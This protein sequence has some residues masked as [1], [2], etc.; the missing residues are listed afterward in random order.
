MSDNGYRVAH[1]LWTGTALVAPSDGS[2]KDQFGMAAIVIESLD[3]QHNIIAVNVVPGLLE[4]QSSFRSELAGL[5]RQVILINATCTVHNITSGAIES[6][7][8]GKVA[9]EK[10]SQFDEQVD[11]N[12]QH[13]DLISAIHTAIRNSPVTWTFRH[14]KGH[15]DEDLDAHLDRWALLNIQ[16]DN[17]TKAYWSEQCTLPQPA[18]IHITGAYWS[19]SIN[20]RQVYSALRSTIY[21]E[22]YRKKMSC[23]WKRQERMSQE[24]SIRVNWDACAIAK[25]WL[26][27]PR[28][29]WV[30][31]HSEGMCGVGRLMLK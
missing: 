3:S 16:M 21:E 13:F 25:Q 14:V 15:Q 24:N 8:D 11:T 12:G 20:S 9:L 10:A 22:I 5:F 29:H 31:K 6:G 2:F 17:L 23:H 30:S 1:A 4:V 18:P 7:C 19:V 27:I 26:K 28:H